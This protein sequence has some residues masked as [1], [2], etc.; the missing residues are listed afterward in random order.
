MAKSK[1]EMI[2]DGKS[3]MTKKSDNMKRNYDA[4][5]DDMIRNFKA[6][7]FKAIRN[8]NYEDSIRAANFR[9]DSAKWADKWEKAMFD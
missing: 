9:T 7:G 6:V 2:D 3:K 1:S 5:K 4:Q 8:D